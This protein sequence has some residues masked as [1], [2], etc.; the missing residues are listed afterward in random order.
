M[1]DASKGFMKDG[2]KNRLRSQDIHKIVDV[3][4]KQI[5]VA[6]YSRMVPLSEIADSK[7]EFN[8][9]IP[10]YIDSS[11]PEDI[12][13]LHAHLHGGIPERDV[14]AL[15]S[16][17]DAFSQLRSQLFKPNRPGYVDLAIDVT[18][19]QQAVLDAPEFKKFANEVAA[20]TRDW[21]IM[22]RPTLDAV[23]KDTR[24]ND[25]IAAMSDDLLLRF[26]QVSLLDA[27]EVYEQL[28]TYWH[29]V[30]HDDVFL[31]MR[32]G[33]VNAARP[34]ATIEDKDRKLS[35]Q[36]DLEVGVGRTKTKYKMDLIPPLVVVAR[37]FADEQARIDG[38]NA[39]AEATTQALEEYVEANGGEEGLLADAIEDDK[40]NKTSATARLRE[41]KLE[42]SDPEEIKALEHLIQLYAEAGAAKKAAKEAQTDLD[43]VT[44]KKY[45][46][47]SEADVRSIVLDDK[48]GAT[49]RDRVAGEVNAITLR[50]V[51]RIQQLGE[52]YAETNDEL[53]CELDALEAKVAGHLADMGIV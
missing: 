11:T 41:A 51:G 22:H 39:T 28:M 5:E 15:S 24:P 16:Y 13:D 23:T 14:D 47:L 50:L 19:V 3:F 18:D 9:N 21:Y 30:M 17:W 2:P 34:R 45:G 4:N 31:V 7:N 38:L 26:K 42:R 27:Y 52:R 43:T 33:W 46:E 37:Y 53:E 44:F 1:I 6:G 40:I 10:R 20:L 35:E 49:I 12:Q 29:G 32:E 25:L 36:P 8:L 48:W